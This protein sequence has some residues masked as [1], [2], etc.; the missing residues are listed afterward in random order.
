M[1]RTIFSKDDG[2]WRH[3]LQ[4]RTPCAVRPQRSGAQE[5][6]DAVCP[7]EMHPEAR[8]VASQ[9]TKRRQRRIPPRRH[10]PEAPETRKAPPDVGN[11]SRLSGVGSFLFADL[12]PKHAAS[13]TDFFNGIVSKA[14]IRLIHHRW[15]GLVPALILSLQ[16]GG[17]R[18]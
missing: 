7:P 18:V 8:S 15:Q 10:R 5:G 9:R 4:Q 11:T 13:A 2:A 6:R 3:G 14:D 16:L 17:Q 1:S 12:M